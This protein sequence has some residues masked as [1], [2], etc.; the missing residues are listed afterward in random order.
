MIDH[1]HIREDKDPVL[2]ADFA[3][4]IAKDLFENFGAKNF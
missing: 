2:G 4:R 3:D 1:D